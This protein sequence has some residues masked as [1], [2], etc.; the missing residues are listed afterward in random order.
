[1]MKFKPAV[2]LFL[3]VCAQILHAQSEN[4]SLILQSPHG[5][6]VKMIWFFKSW[7]SSYNGFDI[8]RREGLQQEWVQLNKHTIFPCLSVKKDLSNVESEKA[9]TERLKSEEI[10][11]IKNHIYKEIDSLTF[12]KRLK[13]D[14]QFL[15]EFSNKISED[16]DLA[17]MSGFGYVDNSP[18]RRIDYEYGL[19]DHRTGTLLAH[20]RWN[21]G[22][23]PDLDLITEITSR[24]DLSKRGVQIIWN[25]DE[26][27]L[28]AG[29]VHGFNI[30]RD[31]I[32]LN[33]DPV[34]VKYNPEI[35]GYEWFDSSAHS[36]TA[37]QYAISSE[38][39]LDIE[40][41][42]KP[43]TYNPADHAT[44]YIRAT[45]S[46]LAAMG[47]YFKEGL[48]ISWEFPSSGNRFLSGFYVEKD[49]M[50]AGYQRVSPLLDPATREFIDKSAT[51]A[52]SFIRCRVI[53]VYKDRSLI[54]SR[55]RIYSYFPMREPPKPMNL[56]ASGAIKNKTF[57]INF[58]WDPPMDGD[59][60]TGTY[61]LYLYDPFQAKLMADNSL[62]SIIGN[63]FS[64]AASGL[65]PG[66]NKFCFSSVGKNGVESQLSD[67]VTVVVPTLN[68]P[69]VLGL[70]AVVNEDKVSLQ[71][72]YPELF[73]LKGFRIYDNDKPVPGQDTINKNSRSFTT[74]PLEYGKEHAFSI[75]AVTIN[76]IESELSD[77]T[78]VLLPPAPKRKR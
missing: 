27:K 10:K 15:A 78:G 59:S 75:S 72:E 16:Y 74:G 43:Y 25:V 53:A 1:M 35:S 38:S 14:D 39:M 48:K 73:D 37:N 4:A 68:P 8:K 6:A 31:G 63:H 44:K 41:I 69:R 12:L 55:A 51:P 60:I 11:D 66:E 64:L 29:Y 5:H 32:R 34:T 17:L 2:T 9:E 20:A 21:F 40:G 50:P 33:Q 26:A 23:V 61:K 77:T 58:E 22:E 46:D 54:K 13:S 24:S 62:P 57:T 70:K 28:K 42:I 18:V 67:T 45:V 49:N 56:S 52:S 36:E 71:W 3:L 19:F 76:K 7:D 47:Y 65:K 30:Y